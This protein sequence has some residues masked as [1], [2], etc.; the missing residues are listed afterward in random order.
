[1]E[2]TAPSVPWYLA[3]TVLVVVAGLALLHSYDLP[4]SVEFAAIVLAMVG[5]SAFLHRRHRTS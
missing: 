2:A 5:P 1:M 4:W 3:L